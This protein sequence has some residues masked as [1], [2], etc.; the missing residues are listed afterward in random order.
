MNDIIDDALSFWPPHETSPLE[1][2]TGLPCDCKGCTIHKM[3]S[4]LT[5]DMELRWSDQQSRGEHRMITETQLASVQAEIERLSSLAYERLTK[6]VEVEVKHQALERQIEQMQMQ[7][8]G[9]TDS[10]HTEVAKM[11]LIMLEVVPIIDDIE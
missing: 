8:Q 3:G 7:H 6:R 1:G 9:E 5:R 11:K 2:V 4:A 10:L